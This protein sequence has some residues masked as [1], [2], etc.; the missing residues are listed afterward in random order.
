[1]I[2]LPLAITVIAV[3]TAIAELPLFDYTIICEHLISRLLHCQSQVEIA[4]EGVG[5]SMIY[6]LGLRKNGFN[7][8]FFHKSYIINQS[9]LLTVHSVA[10][11]T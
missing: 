7:A 1:M 4:N 2:K 8:R 3:I 6:N 11:P 10:S 9:S 5:R